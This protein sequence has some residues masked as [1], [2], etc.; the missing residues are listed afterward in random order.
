MRDFF[1]DLG[2]RITETAETVSKKT[3]EVVGVQKI[4][5]QIRVMERNNERD[6][7][8]IG[9]MVYDKFKHGELVDEKFI[10]L[11]EAVEKRDEAIEDLSKE[12][13]AIQGKDVCSNCKGHIE[14]EMAYCPKCGAKIDDEDDIFEDESENVEYESMDEEVKIEFYVEPEQTEGE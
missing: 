1:E 6:F 3:E 10:E 7:Q 14:P 4:K 9:K 2:K 13:A 11:C 5:S 8:D 12:I